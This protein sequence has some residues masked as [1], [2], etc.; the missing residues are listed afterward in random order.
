MIKQEENEK[1]ISRGVEPVD[2]QNTP[3][4]KYARNSKE[5]Q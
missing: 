5:I 1:E 2:S 3:L 4:K